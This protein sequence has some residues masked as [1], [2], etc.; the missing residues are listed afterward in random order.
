MSANNSFADRVARIEAKTSQSG[1]KAK[2]NGPAPHSP[3]PDFARHSFRFA[4]TV[5]SCMTLAGLVGLALYSLPMIKPL[6]AKDGRLDGSYLEQMMLERMTDEEIDK[7]D[8]D[9]NLQGMTQMNKF[10]MSN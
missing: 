4:W 8:A 1:G 2:D 9:P 10:L 7:M 6:L 5:T 3:G